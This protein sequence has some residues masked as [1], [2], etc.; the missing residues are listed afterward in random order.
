VK[1]TFCSP[2]VTVSNR[3]K[4]APCVLVTGQYGISANMH[5]IMSSS[6]LSN[7]DYGTMARK[8]FEINV[9]HPIMQALFEKVQQGTADAQHTDLAAMLLDSALLQSGFQIES[10]APFQ[11][12]IQRIISSGLSIDPEAAVEEE[13]EEVEEGE[14]EEEEVEE[15]DKATKLEE[16]EKAHE[17]L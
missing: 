8:T 10:M 11:K 16:V 9:M 7:T 6:T 17:E 3:L 4:E 1:N 2:Q 12:R 14:E 15:E 5:R 13:V